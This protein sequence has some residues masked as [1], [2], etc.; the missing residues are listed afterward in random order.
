MRANLIIGAYVIVALL[1]ACTNPSNPSN[2]SNSSNSSQPTKYG[3]TIVANT[4]TPMAE[5]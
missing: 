2:P 4:S 5:A 3:P 1:A